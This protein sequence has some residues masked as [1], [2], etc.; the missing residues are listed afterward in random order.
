MITVCFFPPTER[1]IIAVTTEP[2][3]LDIPNIAIE[4]L[5]RF[6][7]LERH[8]AFSLSLTALLTHT[9]YELSYELSIVIRTIKVTNNMH[10][11]HHQPF[12]ELPDPG[13]VIPLYNV[14]ATNIARGLS[15][16]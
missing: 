9:S 14:W 2:Q 3:Q 15:V 7:Y 16:L 12:E 4:S 13:K 5:S 6:S 11:V 8:S 1:A 10:E